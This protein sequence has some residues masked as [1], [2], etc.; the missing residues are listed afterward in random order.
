MYVRSY[1]K[2]TFVTRIIILCITTIFFIISF[3][4]NIT[5]DSALYDYNLNV[6]P[7]LQ[8]NYVLG[9]HGWMTFMNVIS[10]VFDPMICAAYIFII[11][12]ITYRKLEIIAFLIWFFF[13]SWLLGI[14]KM[15]IHQARPFWIPGSEVKMESW[16]CYTDY[17]CPS[18]HSMLA[19]VLL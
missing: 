3:V 1:R 6:V 11:Y 16:K 15:A 2:K 12:L 7:V 10:F 9:S 19:I 8:S 4:L 14:M 5:S 18:G 17:G 13:L